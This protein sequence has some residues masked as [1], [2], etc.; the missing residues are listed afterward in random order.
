M[1]MPLEQIRN[2]GIIA[3]IDAGKT[4]TTERILFYSGRIHRMGEVHDGTAVTDWMVQERERGITITAAA[5]TTSW[6]DSV[7]GE[8]VQINIIDTPGHIDF[9]AEVQR[10]LRVLDGGVVV[11]DAVAGVEPQSETVWR[12]ADE[13]QVPRICFINKMDRLGANFQRTIDMIVERLRAKPVPIQL[14]WGMEDNFQ[15]ILDLFEMQALRYSD[16]LGAKPEI[17]A[18]PAELL[19]T[20][21]EARQTMIERIAETDDELTLLYLEGEEISNAQLSAALRRA[22][23]ANKLVPVLC[24]TAL[25]NKGVQPL[26]DATIRYLPS[27]LDVPPVVGVDPISGEEV[28]RHA[29]PNEPFSA[30][31]FKIVTDPFV[32][33]LAYVRVYS[34]TLD[35]GTQV[36]N[37]N[38]NSKERIGR[39]LQM[40]ADKR[41]EIKQCRAG[42]I[43]AVVGLKQTFTGE[44]LCDPNEDVLLETINFPEPVIKVAVEPKSK[45][46]QDKMTDGLLKLA[47]ED[48]TFRVQY[49]DQ[50]GQTVISGMGELHLDI[51]VDRLKR[52]F[53][54]QCNVGRPQVAYRETITRTVRA[55]GRFVRQSGGRGQFGHV[56]L[57]LE[58][59]APGAGFV[60]EDKIVGGVV[61][62][63]YIPAVGKGIAE[64]LDSGILAGYPVVDIKAS[65]VDGSYHEVDSSEMA[66]KIAG[67]MAFKE[68]MAKAGPVLLEPMMAVESVAPDEYVGDVVGNFSSRRGQIEGMD[69]RSNGVTA[70]RAMVPLSEM[71]GYATELRSMTSGRGTFTM[72]FHSYQQVSQSV[73]EKVLKR[74]HA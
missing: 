19:E 25:R 60:Y 66:F 45:A 41:E 62:K 42:D 20:A 56:W 47:E 27:P 46:D 52:E 35:A 59:N 53:R 1:A 69:S 11:F 68:G 44:T 43:A 57:V 26:L 22:T 72:Q 13:Y 55:E 3:H 67:S 63:E 61:P 23:I 10:S 2:I 58:P 21:R 51:I 15:G 74:E 4:T 17:V 34:G 5:I 70:I 38:R 7:T 54:V 9:T 24:G 65:L 40:H 50:T 14:P 71:F 31:V 33:R 18:I 30:L 37:A 32:G 28:V 6:K 73:A 12:Q 39:L 29:D 8:E 49:D 16:E 64:A 48:P 36:Y